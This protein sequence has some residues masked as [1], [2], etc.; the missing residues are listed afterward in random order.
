MKEYFVQEKISYEVI[1]WDIKT[2]RYYVCDE[3]E[4]ESDA[5]RLAAELTK[6]ELQENKDR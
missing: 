4:S 5:E 1:E 3:F 2:E 6:E